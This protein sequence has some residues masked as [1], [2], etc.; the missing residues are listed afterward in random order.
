MIP[1]CALATVSM[2]GAAWG[3]AANPDTTESD[4]QQVGTEPLLD[5]SLTNAVKSEA[6]TAARAADVEKG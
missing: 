5:P 4:L 3:C 1:R 6:D 2:L